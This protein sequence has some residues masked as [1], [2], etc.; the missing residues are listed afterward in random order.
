MY[1]CQNHRIIKSGRLVHAKVHAQQLDFFNVRSDALMWL[2]ILNMYIFL[3]ETQSCKK[4]I[5]SNIVFNLF[6]QAQE[7]Q[8]ANSSITFKSCITEDE[9]KCIIN[10]NVCKYFNT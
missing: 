4:K 10:F 7:N 5:N 8:E 3:W 9:Q 1:Q 2:R 6:Y